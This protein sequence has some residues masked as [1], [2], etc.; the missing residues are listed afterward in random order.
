MRIIPLL[1][2]AAL[3]A[4][5]APPEVTN[6]RAGQ[7]A[8]TKLVDITYNLASPDG[9]LSTIQIELSLDGGL[10][11]RAPV[12]T[13]TGAIGENVTAGNNR[14]ATWNA[15]VDFDGNLADNCRARVTAF[16]GDD[17]TPPVGMVYIPPGTFQMGDD[18]TSSATPTIVT[19]T[20]GYFISRSEE[21]FSEF[22]NVNIWGKT[23]GYD[24][25][26]SG[27]IGF[28]V[29]GL[30]WNR[31]CQYAN[32]KSEMEGLE[33]V[34]Y[35]DVEFTVIAKNST[36]LGATRPNFRKPSANG[37]RL[38]TSAEWEMAARGGQVGKRFANGDLISNK[39]ANIFGDSD[40]DYDQS[41]IIGNPAEAVDTGSEA[42][43]VPPLTFAPNGFG[44]FQIDGNLS[45]FVWDHFHNLPVD[46]QIDP[47]G[48]K[49][50]VRGGDYTQRASGIRLGS[51]KR[52]SS[53]RNHTSSTTGVRLV[54]N[55]PE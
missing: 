21:E 42:L 18:H 7:R 50:G 19:I 28:S 3:L 16:D 13:L 53:N 27:S 26:A 9:G 11:W 8:G 49:G 48:H 32:A 55:V 37:F 22:E 14:V 25:N 35:D 38:P 31:A 1:L 41:L 36:S 44:L 5:A 54:R 51:R 47:M 39:T 23:K 4:G 33:P 30:G 6:V 10:S 20:K 15:G 52:F 24:T 45:E 40:I 12:N 43:L 2:A 46:P 29:R 34:Y 17:P